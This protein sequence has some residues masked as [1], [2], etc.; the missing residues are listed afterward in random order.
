[1]KNIFFIL[2][3]LLLLLNGCVGDDILEDRVDPVIR[4]TNPI[5]T[6]ELNTSYQYEADFFNNVGRL[7]TTDITW[8]SS[9]ESIISIDG[10]GIATALQVGN[11][12][13]SAETTAESGEFVRDEKVLA[14]GN[15]TV[16]TPPTL[17]RTGTVATTTFYVLEGDF[18]LTEEDNGELT[19]S[20]ADNYVASAALPGLYVYLT[21]NPNTISGAYEIGPVSVFSGTHSYTLPSSVG[22]MDYEYVLYF[23][24]PFNVKV[25]DG[26]F[27]N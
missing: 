10:D 19:L 11:A 25:G 14:V 12:I 1:M 21:N 5:D 17:E 16:V 27:D 7:T 3:L 15:S 23:C 6:I 8:T 20:F 13:I 18:T 4:I 2:P 9:D 22:L 24:E 26:Q